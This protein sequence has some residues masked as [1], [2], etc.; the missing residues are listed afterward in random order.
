LRRA[1]IA[2]CGPSSSPSASA[3][4]P[5]AGGGATVVPI[6]ITG[7][8]ASRFTLVVMADGYTAADMPQ[9]GATSTST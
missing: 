7:D 1:A 9:F 8:D 2:A 6:Q 4:T 3:Q 5:P